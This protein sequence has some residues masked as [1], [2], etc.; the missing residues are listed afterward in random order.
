MALR[1][2]YEGIDIKEIELYYDTL[3]NQK[4]HS[5]VPLEYYYELVE[6]RKTI[7]TLHPPKG[8]L[9]NMGKNINSKYADYAPNLSVDQNVLLFTSSREE[10]QAVLSKKNED[11]YISQKKK[12]VWSMAMGIK[13][14]IN[15]KE[16]N[17]GSA[18]LSHD[19][20][21][22]YFS[23]CNSTAI[24]SCD[25]FTATLHEDSITWG[26]VKNIREINSNFW[27]SHPAL[28]HNDDT[29]FFASDRPEG[30]GLSDIYFTFKTKNGKWISP[31]N[32][33]PIINT[34]KN[35]LSP[36]FHPKH[37]VLYFSSNG[38]LYNFGEYDIYKSQKNNNY[39]E[40]PK[41]IGPIVNGKG[42]ESYFSI[43][44]ESKNLYYA[45]SVNNEWS[46]QDL[47]SFPLPMEGNPDAN[48]H[49]K[50]SLTDED[51][52]KPFKG[53]VYIIDLDNGIEIA[54]K[55]L[56]SDGTFEF[57]LIDKNNYLIVIQG[58]DFFRI[59]ETFYLNGELDLYKTTKHILSRVKFES[60][61]FDL[62]S[63][64]LKKTM[65]GDLNKIINFLY[66]HPEF[67]LKIEGHTDSDG[68]EARNIILSKS[69]AENIRDYIVLFGGVDESRVDF[70][71]FGSSKPIV[72]E[73]N[74]ENK[75][76]NRRV[77]FHI[78]KNKN[79]K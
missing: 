12:N 39:W 32:L 11:I 23:R 46:I 21:V 27:D 16:F 63:A 69:R 18:F 34:R 42:S 58:D 53:L 8:V 65:Y 24:G 77:E 48:T 29:L 36:F 22:L 28:S 25:I 31:Q 49:I 75:S 51:D 26:N 20:K 41:N 66:D 4:I 72:E 33:G 2:H 9:L 17:E 54:P 43:D 35:D 5:Y 62:G 60:I 19:G 56:N 1:H 40:E 6:H 44:S 38:Q 50:G 7:D 10:K 59:E 76:L 55:Y 52:G 15:T 79:I 14:N 57:D 45:R 73:K 64:D 71:G 67:F 37:R 13:G 47:Y 61:E 3:N 74:E 78:Y 68:N 70:E 30:F